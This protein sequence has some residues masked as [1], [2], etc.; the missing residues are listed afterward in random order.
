VP[1]PIG[2]AV[3]IAAGVSLALMTGFEVTKEAAVLLLDVTMSRQES[4]IWTVVFSGLITTIAA[5]LVLRRQRRLTERVMLE[6]SERV[7]L[8]DVKRRL[9]QRTEEL[10]ASSRELAQEISERRR[11]EQG[12]L[13]SE[14]I[15]RAVFAAMPDLLFRVGR[16]GFCRAAH[17]PEAF[18]VASVSE[19]VGHH[20][21]ERLPADVAVPTLEKIRECLDTSAPQLLEVNMRLAQDERSFE[22]RF[23]RCGS[24]E[25][26]GLVRDITDRVRL[27]R[28][29]AHAQKMESVGRLAGGVAHDFN[30]LLTAILAHT[31]FVQDAVG[32]DHASRTDLE[33]IT[34]SAK[35]GAQL[36]RRLLAV[37]RKQPVSVARVSLPRLVAELDVVLRRT[38]GP[39]IEVRTVVRDAACDVLADAGQLEQV[40]LNLAVNAR[41]AM[42]RG[43][44][45]TVT[46]D[47]D[48]E[49]PDGRARLMVEDTG[50]G[51]DHAT[52][53]R[54]FEPF[55]TT[56]AEGQG[57]GLGLAIVYGIVT[58]SGGTIG[59]ET[60][61]GKGSRFDLRLPL[62]QDEAA[63][64]AA[65]RVVPLGG[66]ETIL[67]A[68]D[69]P[70][71]R[72][73]AVRTLQRFGYQVLIARDGAHAL[74]VARSHPGPLHL[75]L[76]DVLM[77]RMG[78]PEAAER[79][80]RERPGLPVVF[81]SGYTAGHELDPTAARVV[82]KP[83][84]V[85]ELATAV[86]DAIDAAAEAQP[87]RPAA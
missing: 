64:F 4:H 37:A 13:Q 16:D 44:V 47:R 51:M 17:M 31:E 15:N 39:S 77:P 43:G 54:I 36:T 25:V 3:A 40:L 24:D 52:R 55:F 86:R 87:A 14:A 26:M 20:V 79:L 60:A 28:D 69:D 80:K 48:P 35:L 53:D 8:L 18:G 22:V 63:R 46:L 33:G 59:V 30:N 10:E 6:S 74:D 42:P 82:A 76:T 32:P 65:T 61:P 84:A 23:V 62:A 12:L 83:F 41:D 78:G 21:S 73:L 1:P 49:A 81:M 29:L 70:A 67:V 57:T 9:Q 5:T 11:A 45:L 85:E 66:T 71:V 75:L 19:W 58:R 7:R 72:Q 2:K 38:V 34:Q 50:T 68:E 27:E 56:K